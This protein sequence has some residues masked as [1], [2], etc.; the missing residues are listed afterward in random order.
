MTSISSIYQTG[1]IST[2]LY[3]VP[4]GLTY[5][6]TKPDP[7]SQ[8]LIDQFRE[9]MADLKENSKALLGEKTWLVLTDIVADN[10]WVSFL[11][12]RYLTHQQK[13]NSFKNLDSSLQTMA[14]I[15]SFCLAAWLIRI[16]INEVF[17]CTGKF[18]AK[19]SYGPS[20]PQVSYISKE[21][22]KPEEGRKVIQSAVS[23]V[24]S[25]YENAPYQASDLNREFVQPQSHEL[26]TIVTS[27]FSDKLYSGFGINKQELQ[28]N[29]KNE[30]RE[31]FCDI[32]YFTKHQDQI[33]Y[34]QESW[35]WLFCPSTKESMLRRMQQQFTQRNEIEEIVKLNIQRWNYQSY[36]FYHYG[37]GNST[38]LHF[39]ETDQHRLHALI[40]F[41]K[42]NE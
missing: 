11:F 39:S 6:C 37:K 23:Q 17:S 25:F 7:S 22:Q 32:I 33:L 18:V 8:E 36:Q 21:L 26:F 41:Y 24:L 5:I 15:V 12:F 30:N 13:E 9:K 35:K 28:P 19:S 3:V 16:G 27:L 2:L 20:C 40:L 10:T 1:A 29:Q 38:P 31:Q 14:A 34:E 4:K 42:K